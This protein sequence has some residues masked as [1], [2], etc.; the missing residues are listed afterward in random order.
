MKIKSIILII[1]NIIF[2]TN[3][4]SDKLPPMSE[5]TA[6]GIILYSK[7][8]NPK[9]YVLDFQK[10]QASWGHMCSCHVGFGC[11]TTSGKTSF[12]YILGD[13]HTFTIRFGDSS[14]YDYES[15]AKLDKSYYT[16]DKLF[17]GKFICHIVHINKKIKLTH[18]DN[19][20]DFVIIEP[21]SVLIY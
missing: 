13:E 21:K 2:I 10:T 17:D 20:K 19:D 14:L 7:G 5:G 18:G 16:Y 9:T 8:N 11:S 3:V 6:C 4:Y 12:Y 15:S 1:F